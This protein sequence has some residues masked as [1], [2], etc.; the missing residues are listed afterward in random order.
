M[1]PQILIISF[2]NPTEQNP[3]QGIFIQDQAAAVCS[4]RKN[5]A[6]VQVNVLPSNHLIL[7]KEVSE[8]PFFGN[9]RIA[10]DL[11]SRFWKFYYVNP[12]LLARIVFRELN[13]IIPGIKPALIHSNVIF[14][15]GIV[16]YLIS[17]KTGSKMII[18]EHWSKAGRLLKHPLYRSIALKAYLRNSAVIAVSE[19]LSGKIY[20]LTGHKNIIVIPNIVNTEIFSFQPKIIFDGKSLNLACVATWKPPKRLDLIIVSVCSFATGTGYDI[21]L[22]I[23]G[24]GFETGMLRSH[25]TPE[26]LHITWHGYLDKPS[27]ASLL[28]KS[29]I[30]LHAS[31]TETFSI[32]TAEAL[33]TGTPVLAS[34]TGALPGLI[35]ER[36]GI[37]AENNPESWIEKIHEIVNKKF[38]YEAIAMENQSRFSP[39]SVGRAVIEVY[40]NVLSDII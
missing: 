9:R 23:V 32:V 15:C 8:S 38:D 14:P 27:I 26:N 21:N 10:I 18:S 13:K 5:I 3:Q 34:D 12:W 24:K 22:N 16:S 30:F 28:Q 1:N 4:L 33:S 39:D 19:F 40:K 2:W 31:D 36:N 25:K 37:L 11:Y 20:G 17:G 7:K 35:H 6:F 29:H